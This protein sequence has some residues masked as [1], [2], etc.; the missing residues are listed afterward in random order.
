MLLRRAFFGWLLPAAFV[1]P[2]WL[3]IG[4]GVFHSGVWAFLGVL[5]IA[6][7]AVLLGQL[8]LTLLVRARG[9]V[10]HSRAVSWWDVLGFTVWHGLTIAAGFYGSS[11][12]WPLVIAAIVAFLGLFWLSLWQLLREAKPTTVLLRTSAGVGYQPPA[13]TPTPHARDHD[14][15]VI[16]EKP[17]Q[18]GE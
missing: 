11:S 17:Q 18:S 5:L 3:L 9:T 8:V 7:P 13:A 10:R 16:A 4:W 15:V 12:F 2:L 6:V 14:V 1:L